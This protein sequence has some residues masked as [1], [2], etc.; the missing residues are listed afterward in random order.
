MYRLRSGSWHVFRKVFCCSCPLRRHSL[1]EFVDGDASLVA[2]QDGLVMS[3]AQDRD[4][5]ELRAVTAGHFTTEVA[6][7]FLGLAHGAWLCIVGLLTVSLLSA[8]LTYGAVI[9]MKTMWYLSYLLMSI[10]APLGFA[11]KGL[12]RK[13]WLK[14]K[15][16]C[17]AVI[18]IH[19]E[20]QNTYLFESMSSM[21]RS[22]MRSGEAE[23]VVEREEHTA[24]T[25]SWHA[26]LVPFRSVCFLRVTKGSESKMVELVSH[27]AESQSIACGPKTKVVRPRN[28][29]L[30]VVSNS[31]LEML[32]L[33]CWPSHSV[34]LLA[35]QKADMKFLQSWVDDVY[36][37][38]M[39]AQRGIVE[40]LELQQDNADWPPEWQSVRKENAVRGEAESTTMTK[41]RSAVHSAPDVRSTS[42]Y[43]V[44][45]WAERMMK[46]AD[47]AM[48]H[49]GR[50]RTTLFLHGQKGSGKTLF[51]E[52]LASELGLPIY[53][54]DLRASFLNDSVLRDAL[55][56]RKLRHN[57]PVIFHFDEFQSIIE[58]WGDSTKSAP[59][60]HVRQSPPTRVTIQG[61]QS[62]LEGIST[63]NNA[64]FVFTGSQDLPKLDT[65]PPGPIRHEWE[66][67]LRRFPVREMIPPI[68][69]D[70]AIAFVSHFFSQYL[71]EGAI[72]QLQVNQLEAGWDLGT[73]GIPFDMASKY[74]QHR[75]RDSFI[76]GLLVPDRNGMRV[77]PEHI[78]LFVE[79]A[80]DTSGLR[81]WRDSYAGGKLKA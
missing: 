46:H 81:S 25:W 16:G 31:T 65:L 66:G 44:Q 12:W 28:I 24:G 53:Y 32:A 15:D 27:Q 10:F 64:L 23:L 36:R 55:T 72:K 76:E 8:I 59:N 48:K 11:F 33:P 74:C 4:Q 63:P 52:W 62:V 39:R 7:D 21:L 75:L 2:M 50:M 78:D 13:L 42:F 34:K 73:E 51:V 60:E 14:L 37:E 58:A 22:V 61:L 67:M 29:E 56:P 41:R 43:F 6:N 38:Y 19:S 3:E 5:G 9:L 79:R 71:P 17:T 69:R 35:K 77:P 70:A 40:V 80:F 68:G 26:T 18:H 20:G 54:I 49:S 57:L 47:F 30:R 1:T 45:D